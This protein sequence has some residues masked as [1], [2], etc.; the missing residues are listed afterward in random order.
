[1]ADSTPGAEHVLEA[2][3]RVLIPEDEEG[4]KY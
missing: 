1:M 3:G 2:L 4:V